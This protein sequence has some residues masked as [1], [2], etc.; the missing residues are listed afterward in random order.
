[1]SVQNFDFGWRVFDVLEI[2]KAWVRH[3]RGQAAVHVDDG[4][5][6]VEDLRTRHRSTKGR[7]EC[8]QLELRRSVSPNDYAQPT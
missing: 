4:V 2:G 1:M 8:A 6:A 3:V 7:Y 5:C